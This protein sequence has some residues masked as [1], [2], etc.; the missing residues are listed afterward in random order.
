LKA[1]RDGYKTKTGRVIPYLVLV[2]DF[3]R[4]TKGQAES[5]R[6]VLDTIQ[7]RVEGPAGEVYKVLRGTQIIATGNTAGAG[8]V[9]GRCISANIID[10]SLLDRFNRIFEFHW[11]D[12]KDEGKVCAEKFPKLH[13]RFPQ[14][15]DQI[16]KA[17]EILRKTIEDDSLFCEFGHRSVCAWLGH[18]DDIL[19]LNDRVE[20]P[21]LVRRSSRAFLDGMPDKETRLQVER[22]V[23]P[24][25]EG[26]V[27]PDGTSSTSFGR[28]PGSEP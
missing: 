22:L 26:G 24:H 6:L 16:G 13:A 25:I 3:D 7:G 4:A 18:A 11:M 14:M 19:A 23:D 2:T 20:L 27:L 5:L 10:A 12:W 8:D 21:E 1:L 28:R 15:F 17:T 9:R